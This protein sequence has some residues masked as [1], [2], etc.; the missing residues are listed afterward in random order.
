MPRILYVEC[1]ED[2]RPALSEEGIGYCAESLTVVEG[3]DSTAV[4]GRW[5]AY[6]PAPNPTSQKDEE[7]SSAT[8]RPA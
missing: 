8:G 7:D 1:N 4:V 6:V 5:R 2:G 3:L